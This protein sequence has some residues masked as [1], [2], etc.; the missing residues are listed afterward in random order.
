V[1]HGHQVAIGN[2]ICLELRRNIYIYFLCAF[3]TAQHW[4]SWIGWRQ[5]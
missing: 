2:L 4:D 3:S 5:R 1:S